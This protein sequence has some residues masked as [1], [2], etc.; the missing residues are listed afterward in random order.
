M[1]LCLCTPPRRLLLSSLALHPS[2]NIGAVFAICNGNIQLPLPWMSCLHYCIPI[3]YLPTLCMYRGLNRHIDNI[4]LDKERLYGNRRQ[5]TSRVGLELQTAS[6]RI[7]CGRWNQPQLKVIH[8]ANLYSAWTS[9]PHAM[10]TTQ[11]CLTG[12]ITGRAD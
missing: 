4:H 10:T 7:D 5:C 1:V 12:K 6:I 2:L 11:D 8:T 9:E 3:N